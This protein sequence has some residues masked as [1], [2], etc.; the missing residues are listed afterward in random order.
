[1]LPRLFLHC[2]GSLVW[3]AFQLSLRWGHGLFCSVVELA[4]RNGLGGYQGRSNWCRDK[5]DVSWQQTDFRVPWMHLTSSCDHHHHSH[6]D[7]VLR[8]SY[9]CLWHWQSWW[10][11]V[12]GKCFHWFAQHWHCQWHK[13]HL[14]KLL[15]PE[16]SQAQRDSCDITVAKPQ[17]PNQLFSSM[18]S[19]M[20]VGGYM[21]PHQ[22][23]GSLR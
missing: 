9:R 22:Q 3:I 10:D 21:G 8:N 15:K 18:P 2:I 1:M 4:W 6:F 13:M 14:I 12:Y 16:A 23:T 20:K 7:V 5:L 17:V 11:L 19:T